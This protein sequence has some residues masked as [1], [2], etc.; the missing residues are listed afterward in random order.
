VYV[1]DARSRP[2]ECVNWSPG[3][4]EEIRAVFEVESVVVREA[5]DSC[6]VRV[7]VREGYSF[8]SLSV[9]SSFLCVL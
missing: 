4:M 2:G 5:D 6:K 7:M 9:F 8:F 1:R 3:K